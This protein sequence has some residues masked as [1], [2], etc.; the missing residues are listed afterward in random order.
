MNQSCRLGIAMFQLFG[1][2]NLAAQNVTS[3]QIPEAVMFNVARSIST[4]T[5]SNGAILSCY[6]YSGITP[7]DYG[8]IFYKWRST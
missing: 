3:H 1:M 8:L 2:I 6:R 5:S 7:I 4:D